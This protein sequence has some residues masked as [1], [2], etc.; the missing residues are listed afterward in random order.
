MEFNQL[1]KKRRIELGLTM[2]DLARRVG[3]SKAT[4]QRWESGEIKNV[5][6]DKITKLSD[7]L[8][9]TPSYLMGWENHSKILTENEDEELLLLYEKIKKDSNLALI[10]DKASQLD[11]KEVVQILEIINTFKK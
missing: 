6:H 9:T 4:I 3:V 7:A 10:T 1:V 2:E 11:P 8:E 5:R